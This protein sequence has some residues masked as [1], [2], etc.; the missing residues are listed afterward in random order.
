M[1]H[2]IIWFPGYQ[3]HLEKSELCV[4]RI[5]FVDNG[6]DSFVFL[7]L[8]NKIRCLSQIEK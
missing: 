1:F 2:N 6:L 4:D 8:I 5:K 3:L 7:G